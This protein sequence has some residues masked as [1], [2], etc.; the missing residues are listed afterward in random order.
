MRY[1]SGG[2]TLI[3]LLVACIIA[4]ILA[5]IAVPAYT[6]YIGKQKANAAQ[7]DLVSLA[8][9]MET[10]LQNTTAY[11]GTAANIAAI[12]ALN[13][14]MAA[15]VPAQSADFGY[16]ITAVDNSAHT[17]TLTATGSSSAVSG[18]TITLTSANGRSKA[19]CPGGATSW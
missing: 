1:S 3:E 6:G 9:H 2:F 16:A 19:G 8:M 7:M 17:Y 14:T 13:T 5:A 4:A 10:V 12:Q 11:P 18:C 15:W